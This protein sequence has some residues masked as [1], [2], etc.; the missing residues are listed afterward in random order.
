[1][2]LATLMASLAVPWTA[3]MAPDAAEET[4]ASLYEAAKKEGKISIWSSLETSLHQ[5]QWETFSKKCPGI[6]IEAFR[7][8]P[9][10]AINP[11]GKELEKL[12]IPIVFET[13]DVEPGR[14]NLEMVAMAIDGLQ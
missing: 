12:A 4:P 1:M 7:I 11:R 5:K 2:K 6:Q 8:Q 3:A 13:A 9:G 10:P 14:R